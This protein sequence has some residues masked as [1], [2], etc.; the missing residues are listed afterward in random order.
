MASETLQGF[1]PQGCQQS[2]RR[3]KTSTEKTGEREMLRGKCKEQR[4]FW[5]RD[6]SGGKRLPHACIPEGVTECSLG[7]RSTEYNLSQGHCLGL[8]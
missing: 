2:S 4:S 6:G 5:G 7:A 8:S 3:H 1:S